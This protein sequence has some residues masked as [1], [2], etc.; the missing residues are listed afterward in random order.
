[1][2]SKLLYYL[3]CSLPRVSILFFAFVSVIMM[4]IKQ[5]SK[6]CINS[7]AFDQLVIISVLFRDITIL[8]L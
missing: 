6:N 1:M 8:S 3:Q 2:F 5:F 4:R 7:F